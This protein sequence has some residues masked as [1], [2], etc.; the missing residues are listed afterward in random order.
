MEQKEGAPPSYDSFKR[1]A[2]ALP[3]GWEEMKDPKSGRS[4]YVNHNSK[5]T[6]WDRPGVT[7]K[8][9]LPPSYSEVAVNQVPATIAAASVDLN[10]MQAELTSQSTSWIAIGQ[11]VRIKKNYEEIGADEIGTVT[12]TNADG[13]VE[14]L[15]KRKKILFDEGEISEWLEPWGGESD[16]GASSP[17]LPA[18]IDYKEKE[19]KPPVLLKS[20][21]VAG[22]KVR[23]KKNY[24]D[25]L[26]YEVGTASAINPDRSVKVL[27]GKRKVEFDENEISEWL[28]PLGGQSKEFDNPYV[29]RPYASASPREGPIS[30]PKRPS[31][32]GAPQPVYGAQPPVNGEQH[33]SYSGARQSSYGAQC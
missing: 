23:I 3:P 8:P 21:I 31:S 14:A 6:S 26:A 27:F 4:F 28:E 12:S 7:Q 25:I 5:I 9:V 19:A 17:I 10:E 1:A 18:S 22:Q 30:P 2:E 33:P 11:K 15:F 16:E 29:A 24:A 32:Y 20:S 13:S